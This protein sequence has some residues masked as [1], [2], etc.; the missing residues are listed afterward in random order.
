MFFFQPQT[1]AHADTHDTRFPAMPSPRSPPARSGNRLRLSALAVLSAALAVDAAP[2]TSASP[3]SAAFAA[4]T[5]P[6]AALRARLSPGPAGDAA[7]AAAA[8]PS[9]RAP[10][11]AETV[12]FAASAAALGVPAREFERRVL[13]EPAPAHNWSAVPHERRDRR[14]LN[15]LDSWMDA[16]ATWYGG[17][18]GPGP[19]GMSIYT[20]SCG[21]GQ[22]LGNHFVSAWQTDGGYDWGLTDKCGQC[23]EVLCVDGATRGLDWSDL[24]PWGGCVE[25]GRK[26]VTVK[27]SD[28]CPCH[29]P[30]VGNKRWCCGDAVH[31]D[32]SYIAFDAIAVRHRGVVDLKVRPADCGKQGVVAFYQ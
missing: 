32:L 3:V 15:E 10:A 1:H 25:S 28:S 30:N 27:I 2:A 5:S 13:A 6:L 14:R 26:S 7:A 9:A 4:L 22:N 21:F 24:G 11:R 20:G 8:D 16:R 17:K 31:L 23:Y 12:D 29:H 18:D 19:D